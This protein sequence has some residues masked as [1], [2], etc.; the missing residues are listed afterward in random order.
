MGSGNNTPRSGSPAYFKK[1]PAP[2]EQASWFMKWA[3][4]PVAAFKVLITPVLGYVAYEA[5]ASAGVSLPFP[6]PFAPFLFVQHRVPGSP[7]SDPRYQ[8]GVLDFVLIVYYIV[9]WSLCRIL[10]AGRLFTRIGRFYGLKKEGKL[11]RVGEQG[12]AIVYYTASGLWGLRIMSQ[13]PIWWYRT[14]E[15]WLG[16][17]HWDMVPELKQFYLMQSAH[18]LHELMIMVLGFEKPRKDF[19]ELVAHHAV[20]LWLV[21]WSY[22][23]NLTH[24]G[25]SVFVSMDIPDVLLALSKLLNYLQFPRAKVAVFVVFFGVWSYF[26]HWLNLVI[27]HSVWTEFDLIPE[28]HRRWAPPTGAWLTWWMKY[29]IFAPILLLQILNLFWYYLMWRILIRAIRTAGEASDVRSDDE[30]D[31]EEEEEGAKE[32]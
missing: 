6:N 8:K 9:F 22:L 23:I 15:F 1:K 27:L 12:Y 20:T 26:R 29:Q 13:L 19:A 31:G 21:G 3:V 4:D 2:Y 18:W 7:D 25:I 17:P 28:I 16:Y 11:D 30:D 14:E 10:I 5:T 32:K 24:I